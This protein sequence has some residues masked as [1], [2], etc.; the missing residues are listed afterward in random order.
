[1]VECG[2]V[3]YMVFVSGYGGICGGVVISVSI[4][5]F[6]VFISNIF[7]ECFGVS[8]YL[9]FEGVLKEWIEVISLSEELFFDL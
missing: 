2:G 9:K 6:E 8:E 4:F 3:V 1:M 7:I 5:K